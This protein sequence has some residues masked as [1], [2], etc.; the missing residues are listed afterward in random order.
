MDVGLLLGAAHHLVVDEMLGHRRGDASVELRRRHVL[1]LQV[2]AAAGRRVAPEGVDDA[3]LHHVAAADDRAGQVVPVDEQDTFVSDGHLRLLRELIE[4]RL[5]SEFCLRV[6]TLLLHPF[7]H[8]VHHL[9]EVV[10]A[11]GLL[12]VTSR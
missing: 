10:G 11:F 12:C 7:G 3:P 2:A 5:I 1:V 6:P 4:A 9:C 8:D